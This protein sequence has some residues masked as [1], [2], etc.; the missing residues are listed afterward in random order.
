MIFFGRKKMAAAVA[1]FVFMGACGWFWRHREYI[2]FISQPLSIGA[3]PFTYTASRTALSF[4]Q[5]LDLLSG[6]WGNWNELDALRKENESLRAVLLSSP[7]TTG[8]GHRRWSS[9]A[10]VTAASRSICLS[11]SRRGLWAL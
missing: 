1:L 4:T 9:T 10:A 6:A 2:P 11:S 8:D 7:A 5:G 3:A